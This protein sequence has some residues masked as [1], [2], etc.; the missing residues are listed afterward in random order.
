MQGARGQGADPAACHHH[1]DHAVG[2]GGIMILTRTFTSDLHVRDDDRV[3]T[4]T[5]VPYG[6]PVRI[7][8]YGKTYTEDFAPG[9]FAADVA[10]ANEIELTALHPRSGADL[11]IG[12]T[13]TLTDTPTG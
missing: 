4:G 12:V 2:G 10:R 9:A 8:E 7:R 11:P 1:Q 6:E 3:I 13:L 5:L